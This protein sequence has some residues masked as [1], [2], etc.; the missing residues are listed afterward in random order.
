MTSRQ[1]SGIVCLIIGLALAGIAVKNTFLTP[2]IAVDDP[3]GLGVSRMVGAFLP[4]VLVSAL[5]LWLMQ[6][7]P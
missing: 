3:S 7:K 5:G 4:A 1:T 2:G 6:K